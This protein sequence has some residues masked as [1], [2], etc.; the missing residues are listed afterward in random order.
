[1]ED[2]PKKFFRLAPGREVRLRYGYFITCDEV[3]NNDDGQVIELRC[4]YDPATKGGDAPDGR[5]PKGTLH[6]VSATHSVP[7]EVR[8]YDRLFASP[9]PDEGEEDFITHLNPESLVVLKNARVEPSVLDDPADTRYQFERQGYFWRDPEDSSEDALVFNRIIS[10]RDS[11]AK[12]AKQPAPP[13]SSSKPKP[14]NTRNQSQERRDPVAELSAVE[15]ARFDHLNQRFDLQDEEAV[16]LAREPKFADL[17]L[18]AVAAHDNPQALANWTVHELR[19][20]TSEPSALPFGGAALGQLVALI[21]ANTISTRIAKD[22]FEEMLNTGEAP[23]AIVEK[24]GLKQVSDAD[25]LVP[26]VE[27]IL[28]RFPDKVAQYRDGKTGLIGFFM[29]QLMRETKGQADPGLAKSL[30]QAKL[31]A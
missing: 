8:L 7:A 18:E 3:I 27:E 4:S 1:M 11:W 6:W 24:R 15:K 20:A 13:R 5:S 30:L 19:A 10:L 22:V 29:G 9:T 31:G 2:P 26:V 17:F 16:V 28:D 21:D 23:E 12:R 14:E 25:V